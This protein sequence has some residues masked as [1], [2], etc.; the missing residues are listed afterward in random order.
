MAFASFLANK[1]DYSMSMIDSCA[2][3]FSER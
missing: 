3:C 1:V 2:V